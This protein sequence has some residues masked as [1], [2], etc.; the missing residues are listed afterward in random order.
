MAAAGPCTPGQERARG[1]A[2]SAGRGCPKKPPRPA[3]EAGPPAARS[4]AEDSRGRPTSRRTLGRVPDRDVVTPGSRVPS[5]SPWLRQGSAGTSFTEPHAWGNGDPWASPPS[6]F[7]PAALAS[8]PWPQTDTYQ[9]HVF[10][11]H[12][13]A[14][15][16]PHSRRWIFYPGSQGRDSPTLGHFFRCP[17]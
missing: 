5:L 16:I 9:K 7:K 13:P 15:Q 10:P 3:P 11:T 2:G 14:E 1:E 4:C 12:T 8:V 17:L 6:G